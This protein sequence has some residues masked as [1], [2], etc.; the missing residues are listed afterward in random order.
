[1]NKKE[2][3]QALIK[4]LKLEPLP[5]E[6]GW[7]RQTYLSG[8]TLPAAVLPE[9]YGSN[10]PLSTVIYYLLDGTP[11]CFSCMHLLKTPETYH[12]YLG[13]PV[14]MLLLH[15]DGRSQVV[16]F[17]PDIL[18]GQVVQF[19]VPEGV[20]QGSHLAPGSEYSLMGTTMTPGY[21]DD[22]FSLGHRA[23]LQARYPQVAGLIAALTRV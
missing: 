1:M 18:N 5:V 4:A 7:F 3:A 21:V 22:D 10:R 11:D 6:G 20:W 12:F 16:I 14:E 23:E 9:R 2:M 17:G 19:T 8:E 13:D 15:P